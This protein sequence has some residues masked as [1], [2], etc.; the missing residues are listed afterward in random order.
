[1]PAGDS[2][3]YR[4]EGARKTALLTKIRTLAPQRGLSPQ[5]LRREYVLQRFLAL[6]FA[7]QP[8]PWVL[9]GGSGLLIRLP[10][11]RHSED[12][13]LL[14]ARGDLHVALDGLRALCQDTP[15]NPFR[16]ALTPVDPMTGHAEGTS[17]K[18]IASMAAA[19][20]DRFSVD[21]SV[22]PTFDGII[23]RQVPTPILILGGVDPPPPVSLYPLPAQIAD[24]VAAMLER[25]GPTRTT[26]STRYRDLVD[27]VL[28]TQ[29]FDIDAARTRTALH[30]QAARRSLTLPATLRSPAPLWVSGYRTEAAR[31]SLHPRLHTL[32]T[33]LDVAGALLNP[34]LNGTRTTGTWSAHHQSWRPPPDPA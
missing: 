34:L 8:S 27:L 4:S 23:D 19:V 10:G 2:P 31:S 21:L 24:K 7:A 20:F 30:T 22:Q 15:P 13:D 9:K 18:F 33:A 26:A 14:D 28:I 16:Y 25:H 12:I 6:L 5:A 1:M 11:A 32:T 29:N 17:V 3:R